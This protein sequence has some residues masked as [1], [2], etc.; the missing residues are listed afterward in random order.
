MG[1]VSQRQLCARRHPKAAGP[2]TCPWCIIGVYRLD[3]V[4]A[5]RF[6]GVPINIRHHPVLLMPYCPPEGLRI[7][8]LLKA[9][10]GITDP[11]AAWRRPHAEARA[12]G[13]DLDLSRQPMAYPTLPAHTLIRFAATRGTQHELV[14]AIMDAYFLDSLDIGDAHVLADIA[15]RHG[16]ERDFARALVVDPAELEQTREEAAGS[17][18]KDVTMVPHVAIGDRALIGCRSEDEIADAVEAALSR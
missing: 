16:I 13:L 2:Q 5:E 7:P 15:A 3:K 14:R 17:R 6:P 4:L 8:D 1:G 18:A 12:P 9:R 10:H 11:A